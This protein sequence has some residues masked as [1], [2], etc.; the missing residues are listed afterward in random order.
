MGPSQHHN[1][2]DLCLLLAQHWGSVKANEFI[3]NLPRSFIQKVLTV[4]TVFPDQK[5]KYTPSHGDP[6][7]SPS[8]LKAYFLRLAW[9]HRSS[10]KSQALSFSWGLVLYLKAEGGGAEVSLGVRALSQPSVLPVGVTP[11]G[12]TI[13]RCRPG[14]ASF[15]SCLGCLG[16]Q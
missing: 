14:S 3:Y 12:E 1:S 11:Q 10:P 15:F 5:V 13:Q 2:A 8:G 16:V 9:P 4:F 7:K 6:R